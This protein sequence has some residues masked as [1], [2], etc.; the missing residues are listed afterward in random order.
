ML[1]KIVGKCTFEEVAIVLV[2]V[3]D[4][5]ERIIGK[6]ISLKGHIVKVVYSRSVAMALC[7]A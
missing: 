4:K 6:S 1:G 3:G 5:L 2:A 7:S